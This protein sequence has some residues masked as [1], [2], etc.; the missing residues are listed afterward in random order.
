MSKR[1]IITLA[2]GEGLDEKLAVLLDWHEKRKF[3]SAG[4]FIL[5]GEG[6]DL[7][8]WPPFGWRITGIE[9]AHDQGK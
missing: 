6:T 5:I 1:L 4:E 2:D 3:S 8:D 9:V 7:P